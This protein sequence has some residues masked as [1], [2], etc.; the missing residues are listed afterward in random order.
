MTWKIGAELFAFYSN[1]EKRIRDNMY[2]MRDVGFEACFFPLLLEEPKRMESYLEL[3]DKLGLEVDQV[4][5]SFEGIN[6]IWYDDETGETPF[7]TAMDSV[8]FCADHGVKRMVMHDSSGRIAPYMGNTG[9]QRFRRILEHA[10]ERGVLVCFE[11]VRRTNY[12][13]R[14]LFEN[15]DLK[16]GFCWDA[17]HEVCY[18]PGVEHLALFGD[19]LACTHIHDNR[20][21]YTKDDHLLPFDGANDWGRDAVLLARSGY[22]GTLCCELKRDATKYVGM[23]DEEFCKE[24]YARMVKFA[25]MCQEAI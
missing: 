20:G 19:I 10:N 5:E 21:I 13:A 2:Q 6:N 24:A 15:R 12:L 18:T 23:T 14:I 7:R 25:A 16:V 9:L 17:G 8:D 11:N 4:H 1:D 22:K 3:A